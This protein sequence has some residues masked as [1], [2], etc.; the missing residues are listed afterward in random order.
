LSN[1]VASTF[2]NCTRET[3]VHGLVRLLPSQSTIVEILENVPS[4]PEVMTA[5]RRLR[6]PDTR[7]PSMTNVAG[8]AREPMDDQKVASFY[9]QAQQ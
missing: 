2:L 6:K 1:V 5:C 9:W 8:D 7:S 3:L 4:D